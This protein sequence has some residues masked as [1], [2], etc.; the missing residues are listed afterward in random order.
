MQILQHILT[1]SKNSPH[2][3]ERKNNG[4]PSQNI[5]IES[6]QPS[7]EMK[8]FTFGVCVC[9]EYDAYAGTYTT[10]SIERKN[11]LNHVKY[12]PIPDN[13]SS[14]HLNERQ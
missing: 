5:L 11:T 12:I 10:S 9:I 4:K 2:K 14:I 7:I 1:K 3:D 13:I 8:I 6:V